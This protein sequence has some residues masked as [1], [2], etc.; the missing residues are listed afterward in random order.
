VAGSFQQYSLLF[1]AVNGAL[2]TEEAKLSI[3]RVSGG[4]IIETVARGLAGVSP[5]APMITG[6][7]SNMI[8]A[9]GI[10]FDAG[11]YIVGLT[12]VSLK[13]VQTNGQGLVGQAI[14]MDDDTA[15]GVGI[16]AG[17]D[18]A[19]VMQWTVWQ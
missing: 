7:V 3:K 4:K 16:A 6:S 18:F 8:P 15:H 1:C 5:G 2:L 17:Y 14:I 13:F 12:P 9:A 11:P 10:E 19:F